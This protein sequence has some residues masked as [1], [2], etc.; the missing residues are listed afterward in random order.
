MKKIIVCLFIFI[1]LGL[2]VFGN[3]SDVI[4]KVDDM[5]KRFQY[6]DC[7]KLL[8]DNLSKAVSNRDKAEIYWRL[9]RAIVH[10]SDD[11]ELTGGSASERLKLYEQGEDMAQ[12]A[13]D[14]DKKSYLAYYWKSANIGRWG[15]TKGILDSL[16]KAEPMRKLLDSA[17]NIQENHAGSY[18]VLG[19]LYDELPGWPISFG[20]IEAAVSLGRRSVLLNHED[21]RA[22]REDKQYDFYI[23]L[24]KHLFKRNWNS[25]TR[26]RKMKEIKTKWDKTK[27]NRLKKY[28]YY[29]GTIPIPASMSDKE[30]AKQILTT[31]I[32]ELES[33]NRHKNQDKDLK[34]ARE[35]LSQH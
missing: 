18:F 9:A 15:Q 20:N 11:L 16:F 2:Y 32:G 19:E 8:E 12:K 6:K 7:I 30:E 25:K 24:A 17:I 28:F 26:K 13:I 21:V 34:A 1:F 23:K 27:G 35:L 33:M 10:H 5:H 31:I 14:I 29:E 22:G 4:Q 3:I